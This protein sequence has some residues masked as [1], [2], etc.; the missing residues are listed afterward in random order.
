MNSSSFLS[1]DL[2]SACPHARCFLSL[3]A[4]GFHHGRWLCSLRPR[5]ASSQHPRGLF[6][7]VEAALW[8][9]PSRQSFSR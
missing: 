2:S 9:Q 7:V 3:T 6:S 5:T 8:A 1:H 4:L